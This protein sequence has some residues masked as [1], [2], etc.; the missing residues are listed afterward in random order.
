MTVDIMKWEAMQQRWH[1]IWHTWHG[2]E[3]N[4]QQHR[5]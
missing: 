2:Q 4:F 1:Y 3:T 5:P